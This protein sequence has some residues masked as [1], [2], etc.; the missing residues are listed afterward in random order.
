[1]QN[2]KDTPQKSAGTDTPRKSTGGM[3]REKATPG[4]THR[5]R[6][7]LEVL[8]GLRKIISKC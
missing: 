6:A 8:K 7:R 3:H 1:M 2:G 4:E 5:E